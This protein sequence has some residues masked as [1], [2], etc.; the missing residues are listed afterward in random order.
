[1]C[2][3]AL[4]RGFRNTGWRRVRSGFVG[5]LETEILQSTAP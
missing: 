3:L 2:M 4:R 1:M 5:A